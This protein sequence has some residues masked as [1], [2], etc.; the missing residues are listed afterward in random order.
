MK[1]VHAF[2]PGSPTTEVGGEAPP[3]QF[4]GFPE[5][6]G[7]LDKA[8]KDQNPK[9]IDSGSRRVPASRAKLPTFPDRSPGG[10]RAFRLPK[11]AN[12]CF[13]LAASFGT[14][15]LYGYT[16]ICRAPTS[17]FSIVL[18]VPGSSLR[19]RFWAGG[20]LGHLAGAQAKVLILRCSGYCY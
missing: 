10:G 6:G 14:A 7:R 2:P 1:P 5:G 11:S 19:A 16:R 15:F 3:P 12:L 8:P 13:Y 18:P 4:V 9:F 20:P 17:G